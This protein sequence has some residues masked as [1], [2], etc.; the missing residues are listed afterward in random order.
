MASVL[1]NILCITIIPQSSVVLYS[2]NC[3]VCETSNVINRWDDLIR[4]YQTQFASDMF[5]QLIETPS[6]PHSVLHF[7]RCIRHL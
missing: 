7:I 6:A 4:L 2:V 3:D 5:I 1:Y